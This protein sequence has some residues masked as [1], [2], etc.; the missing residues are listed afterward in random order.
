MKLIKLIVGLAFVTALTTQAQT[1]TF[2]PKL[3]KAGV[4]PFADVVISYTNIYAA[5]E[6][7][8]NVGL[9]DSYVN[10]V[11]K[12]GYGVAIGGTYWNTLHSGTGIRAGMDDLRSINP[13]LFDYTEATYSVRAIWS[14][15]AYGGRLALGKSFKDG[16]VYTEPSFT[17]E[18]RF[19]PRFGLQGDVGYKF[20]TTQ[21][22]GLDGELG[23]AWA[24]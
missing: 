2:W 11:K 3:Y 4:Q 22:Q 5:H 10:V 7:E 19:S 21:G 12:A 18:F 24:F 6:M 13:Y 1:N 15:L 20:T 16:S 17:L 23:L 8:L 9:A 14:R